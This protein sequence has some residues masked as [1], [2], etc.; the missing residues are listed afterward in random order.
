MGMLDQVLSA[1]R[2]HER[3]LQDRGV[4]HAAVFGS[5]AR[6]EERPDSDVDILV[7]LDARRRIGLFAYAG[8]ARRLGE[9]VGRPVD[10]AD[11]EALRPILRQEVEQD[12]A[13]AF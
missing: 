11:S 3:E 4:L 7:T 2:R 1:L 6:G 12:R 9:I 5:V 10:M 13:E 8:I